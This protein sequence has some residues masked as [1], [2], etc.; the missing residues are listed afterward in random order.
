M[1]RVPL[2]CLG[3]C[4]MQIPST[5]RPAME[6]IQL[7]RGMQSAS[8]VKSTSFFAILNALSRARFLGL[9]MTGKSWGSDST[10]NRGCVAANVSRI[11]FVRSV[12][13]SSTQITSHSPM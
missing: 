9:A 3:P 13:R 7:L 10:R 12:E 2:F 5:N 11:S 4:T 6:V 1:E 8:I